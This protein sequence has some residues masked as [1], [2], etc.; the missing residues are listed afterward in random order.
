MRGLISCSTGK[1]TF[2]R[3]IGIEEIRISHKDGELSLSSLSMVNNARL[4]NRTLQKSIPNEGGNLVFY[5]LLEGERA[6][7]IGLPLTGQPGLLV[8]FDSALPHEV[9]PVTRGIG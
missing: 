2:Y 6:A 8:A 3:P 1:V 5:N 9:K 4:E 7:R